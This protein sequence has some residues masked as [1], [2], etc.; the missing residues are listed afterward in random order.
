MKKLYFYQIFLL[1]SK[2]CRKPFFILIAN[3]FS[4]YNVC[5]KYKI[6]SAQARHHHRPGLHFSVWTMVLGS[7]WIIYLF[8]FLSKGKKI[9]N[10][11]LKVKKKVEV[12]YFIVM[13]KTH[14][15]FEIA[16][17]KRQEGN[18]LFSWPTT[19]VPVKSISF[20]FIV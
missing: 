9:C 1:R 11:K 13:Y 17:F 5:N 12:F 15:F 20:C 4:L 7:N 18:I 3:V 6:G 2:G 16:S 8:F 14:K 10:N 19:L